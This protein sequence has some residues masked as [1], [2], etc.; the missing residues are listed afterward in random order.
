MAAKNSIQ[1]KRLP[2]DLDLF[3]QLTNNIMRKYVSDFE[4]VNTLANYKRRKLRSS[5]VTSRSVSSLPLL[6]V[7]EPEVPNGQGMVDE[8]VPT[9]TQSHPCSPRATRKGFTTFL[10]GTQYIIGK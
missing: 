5:G 9:E 7:T 1:S 8:Y 2:Y 3:S 4:L 10:D 6:K